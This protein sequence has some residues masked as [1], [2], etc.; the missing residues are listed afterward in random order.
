MPI[1]LPPASIQFG[2]PAEV[3]LVGLSFGLRPE[4][5]WGT[6]AH[7]LRLAVGALAGPELVF[8]PVTAG[9]RLNLLPQRRLHP[10]LGLGWEWQNFLTGGEP[11]T[12]GAA[13]MELGLLGDLDGRWSV[14]GHLTSDFAL[15][16]GLGFGM[17][18][19]IGVWY[20]PDPRD[21]G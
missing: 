21:P 14:G 5:T 8:L 6:P 3:A 9:Y 10:Q 7:R 4:V 19:Q 15:V 12:R 16:G 18:A 2:L 17:T 1:E 20:R 11:V 13:M